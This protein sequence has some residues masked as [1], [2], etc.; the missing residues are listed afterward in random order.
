MSESDIASMYRALIRLTQLLHFNY[1]ILLW[2][3]PSPIYLLSVRGDDP[4]LIICPLCPYAL[5]SD[6][7]ICPP[8][9]LSL[10]MFTLQG[11]GHAEVPQ[12]YYWI[13][14]GD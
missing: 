7:S 6:L 10:S 9:K 2:E 1:E 14:M 5:Q 12:V 4:V 8:L 13:R 3:V 11:Y